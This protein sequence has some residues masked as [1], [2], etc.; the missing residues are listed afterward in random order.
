MT[1]PKTAKPGG[2]L[3]TQLRSALNTVSSYKALIFFLV[4]AAF[5]SFIVW[6][7]NVFSN[8]PASASEETAQTAAQPHIDPATVAKIQSLQDNSVNVQ[9]LFDAARQNPFQE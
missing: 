3:T 5:Y 2:D 7:I 4:V 6:R 9:S 1:Q 8:A